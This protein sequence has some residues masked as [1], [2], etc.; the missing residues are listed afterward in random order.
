MYEPNTDIV[1]ISPPEVDPIHVTYVNNE[2]GTVIKTE[3]VPVNLY[4]GSLDAETGILT[5]DRR[6]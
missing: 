2:D 5:I 3:A 6:W 4:E 1:V